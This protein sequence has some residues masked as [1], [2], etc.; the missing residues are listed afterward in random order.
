MDLTELNLSHPLLLH[1]SDT[2]SIFFSELSRI[3]RLVNPDI[4]IH[5]GDLVDNIK[6]QLYPGAIRHYEREV[7]SL[8]K[9]LQY[10]SAREIH[11]SIG[12]H[13]ASEYIH[14]KAGR[15]LV[16]DTPHLIRPNGYDIAFDHYLH[17]LESLKANLY[18]YGHDLSEAPQKTESVYLNGISTLNI[19]DLID[20]RIYRYAYP[21]GI[22]DARLNKKSIGI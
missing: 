10:S 20:H 13:D 4:I 19:I 6:L 3:I 15:I 7:L 16:H 18:L 22:D 9:I 14:S 12:N 5:T 8:I 17:N 1:V 11:I 2:P 21:W